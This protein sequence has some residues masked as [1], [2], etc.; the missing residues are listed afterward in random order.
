MDFETLMSTNYDELIHNQDCRVLLTN[1]LDTIDSVED[2]D[3]FYV[4]ALTKVGTHLAVEDPDYFTTPQLEKLIQF[5]YQG[6]EISRKKVEKEIIKEKGNPVRYTVM[7]GHFLGHAGS[8]NCI[9][10]ERTKNISYALNSYDLYLDSA[11]ICLEV[12]ENYSIK[13]CSY[14]TSLSWKAYKTS[15]DPKW[16]ERIIET[17][18]TYI[19]ISDK[20]DESHAH[21]LNLRAR[22]EFEA[23]KIFDEVGFL[24]DSIESYN[25]ALEICNEQNPD[26]FFSLNM[27]LGKSLMELSFLDKED[28]TPVIK[29]HEAYIRAHN[30][31][32][33][34]DHKK[35]SDAILLAGKASLIL[36]Y[37]TKER[38]NLERSLDEILRAKELLDINDQSNITICYGIAADISK[39]LFFE[40]DNLT[41]AKKARRFYDKYFEFYDQNPNLISKKHFDKANKEYITLKLKLRKKKDRKGGR[42]PPNKKRRRY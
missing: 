28:P 32:L 29:Q 33:F 23:Y 5:N 16:L 1:Y 11:K 4:K 7:E 42:R 9:L 8:I 38:E 39:I 37:K 20:L 31:Q 6:S 3:I 41:Y 2:R 40:T 36:F 10:F 15:K 25:E 21:A 35:S 26:L 19:D 22:A 24:Q 34:E 14:M 17:S 27:F 18:T 30:S 13:S 12:D